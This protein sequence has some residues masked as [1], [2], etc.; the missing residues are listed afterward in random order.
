MTLNQGHMGKED[1]D[2]AYYNVSG[3]LITLLLHN[4]FK[5]TL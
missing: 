4:L 5:L 1:D 2:N 3:A